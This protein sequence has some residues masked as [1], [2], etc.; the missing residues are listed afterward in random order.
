MGTAG[1]EHLTSAQSPITEIFLSE[2]ATA[3]Q[4]LA[5]KANDFT[6]REFIESRI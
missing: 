3:K 6:A 4:A 2:S 1:Q 5:L